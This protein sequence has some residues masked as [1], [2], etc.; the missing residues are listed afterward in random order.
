MLFVIAADGL[1][2]VYSPG[3]YTLNLNNSTSPS[4]TT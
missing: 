3:A 1:T 2:S 4:F